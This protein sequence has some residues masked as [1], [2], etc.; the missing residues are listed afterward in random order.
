MTSIDSDVC[1]VR[2]ALLPAARRDLARAG[3][4]GPS[5]RAGIP[6]AICA[7]LVA[8]GAAAAATGV[9]F[10][11]PKVD[12][13]VPAAA[14]WEYFAH[15]P[16]SPTGEGGPVVMRPKPEALAR[17]NRAQEKALLARGITAQCGTDTAHPLA[18]YLPSGDIVPGD[19]AAAAYAAL[20]GD[21]VLESSRDHYEIRFLS[22]AEGRRW[23]CDHPRPGETV[24]DC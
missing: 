15:H 3:G 20:E 5:R 11:D 12:P 19:D 13:A 18:C 22:E 6:L 17:T 21:D 9:I 2:D 8:G 7:T 16:W 4:R 10:A 14:E 1:A 23:R 24:K